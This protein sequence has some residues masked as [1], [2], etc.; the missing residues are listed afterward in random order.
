MASIELTNI[1]LTYRGGARAVVDLDLAVADGELL[2]LVGPSGSGKTSVLRLIAGLERAETGS[3]RIGDRVV[4]RVP[5]GSRDVAMV[6]QDYPLYP[7]LTVRR[8]LAFVPSQRRTP[9]AEIERRVEEVATMLD[10]VDLLDRR[11][12]ALS[13][14]EQQRV[15]VGRAMVRRAA[16]IL[17]DEPLSNLDAMR[18]A[19]LRE[20]IR[21]LHERSGTTTVY[22]THDP[23]EAMSI[24]DRIGV[25]RDGRLLQVG[26]PEEIYRRPAD[27]HVA[28]LL[29][30]PPMNL[31]AGH[32][33]VA[34]GR[35]VF[36]D[37]RDV[38]HAL[39]QSF[40]DLANGA[41][42]LGF[43]PESVRVTA[44]DPATP[45]EV[46][47]VAATVESSHFVGAEREIVARTES[48]L[49]IIART[50][51]EFPVGARVSVLAPADALHVFAADDSGRRIN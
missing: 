7:H 15:A 50:R 16:C 27:R 19:R 30:S 12:E 2:V 5:P 11:P 4:D 21:E 25:L 33:E 3:I 18:R 22:V 28:A 20:E 32:V 44:D 8:N 36:R 10:L 23:E 51:E 45:P 35:P 14:G 9:R 47:C 1:S 49:R 46:G 34:V 13:G 42:V 48:G 39:P 43:R 41:S 40:R 17:Y 6:F 26:P 24:A 29:G 38:T 37:E 31:L